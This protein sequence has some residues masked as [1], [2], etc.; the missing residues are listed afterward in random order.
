MGWLIALT[1]VSVLVLA[2]IGLGPTTFFGGVAAGLKTLMTN[3][4]ISATIGQIQGYVSNMISAGS[5]H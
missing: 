3:P 1:V 2:L 5:M 4:Q